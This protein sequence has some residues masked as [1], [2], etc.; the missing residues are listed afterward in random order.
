MVLEDNAP[1]KARLK[2]KAMPVKE[3]IETTTADGQSGLMVSNNNKA[4]WV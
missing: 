4:P 3:F 2:T 1:L